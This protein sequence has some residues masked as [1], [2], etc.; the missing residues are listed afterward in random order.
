MTEAPTP[1]HTLSSATRIGVLGDTHGDLEH[2][3][4][5]SAHMKERGVH[6]L[7]VLGDFGFIWP[8]RN[9]GIDLSKL[10]RRLAARKQS[11][12]FVDG[13][14]EDFTRLY[15]YPVGA[16]GLRWFR[17]NIAHLPRGYRTVLRSGKTLAALGG[18]ASVDFEH[19]I[20]GRSWWLEETITDQ[21]LQNLGNEHADVL[22]GH[23]AP[24]GVPALESHLA[25]T[26]HLWPPRGVEYSNHG[27]QVFHH[28]FMQVRPSLYLGGHY[29]VHVDQAVEFHDTAGAFTSRIVILDMNGSA[30]TIS[31]AVLDVETLQ[32]DFV[33]LRD[34]HQ[35]CEPGTLSK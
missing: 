23:D 10:S 7:L 9:W 29:H 21:D 15:R 22:V 20:V 27:R 28:G 3:L 11:L 5:V 6:V 16:D 32:L 30:T 35:P 13:N 25:A 26:T 4:T 19:R 1:R 31:Q 18:A 24:V 17:N 2:V 12:F 33:T 8:R 34:G 14:H